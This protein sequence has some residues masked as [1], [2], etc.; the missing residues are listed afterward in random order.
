MNMDDVRSILSI[1]HINHNR[2]VPDGLADIWA[3]TLD[4]VAFEPA[5]AAALH[6]IKT[7]PHLPKV[8]E[9]REHARR[10]EADE[11]ARRRLIL[12]AGRRPPTPIGQP[13][14]PPVRNG[15]DLVRCVLAALKAA[16]QD[17]AKGKFLGKKRAAD[18]AEQ[19]AQEW[20]KATAGQAKATRPSTQV[21]RFE[22]PCSH[23]QP[24]GLNHIKSTGKPR[25]PMCRMET[26]LIHSPR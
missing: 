18:I 7:S 26:E 14:G 6:F 11:E 21:N 8:S 2:A 16:G 23:G 5:K 10:I 24:G 1:L 12:A 13:A 25:C 15:A 17:P 19:A 3:A 9:I 4:D 22:V 20:L